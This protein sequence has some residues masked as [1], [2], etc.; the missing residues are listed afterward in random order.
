MYRVIL[1]RNYYN[2]NKFSRIFSFEKESETMGTVLTVPFFNLGTIRT[3]PTVPFLQQEL[4]GEQRD[5]SQRYPKG[6]A[7]S[8]P[9]RYQLNFSL[10]NN[11][12]NT[13]LYIDFFNNRFSINVNLDIFHAVGFLDH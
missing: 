5:G 6:N 8:R 13:S 4:P 3:V 11:I 7:E 9:C 1:L 12:H 2:V 10:N